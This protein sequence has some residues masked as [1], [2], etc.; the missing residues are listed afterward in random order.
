MVVTIF[1]RTGRVILGLLVCGCAS[2]GAVSFAEAQCIPFDQRPSAEK[3]A[4]FAE[5]PG[6]VLRTFRGNNSKIE[7][8]VASYLASAPDLLPSVRKLIADAPTVNKSAIG[9][10]LRRAESQ[11]LA[12]KP[13]VARKINNFVRTLGDEVVFAGYI[14]VSEDSTL[15]SAPGRPDSHPQR[16]N[17]LFSGEWNDKIADPF[18]SVPLPQ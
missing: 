13:E 7:W 8:T 1:R 17:K 5:N 2:F 18:E 11:C 4:G 3:L 10:A 14:S 12:P 9:A 16:S 15:Q 6:A